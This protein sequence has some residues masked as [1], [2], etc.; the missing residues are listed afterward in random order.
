MKRISGTSLDQVM[1][2]AK[3]LDPHGRIE[4]LQALPIH[5]GAQFTWRT[6]VPGQGVYMGPADKYTNEDGEEYMALAD[7][8]TLIPEN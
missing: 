7:P 3:E 6:R 4:L 2:R 5:P 1:A 8:D